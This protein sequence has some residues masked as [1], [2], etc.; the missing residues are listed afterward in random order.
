MKAEINKD[1]E[2]VQILLYLSEQQAQTIQCINNKIYTVAISEWFAPHKSHPAVQLTKDLICN[3]NFIHI[4]PLQAIL[5]LKDIIANQEHPLY[6]WGTAVAD[7]RETSG[8][9]AF[10]E[11]QSD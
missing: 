9:D 4:R 10:F 3:E 1:I 2:L 6:A 8:F 5:S 11:S 7:F